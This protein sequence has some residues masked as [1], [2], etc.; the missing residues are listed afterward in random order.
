MKLKLVVVSMSVLG[1]VCSPAFAATTVKHKHAHKHH[2]RHYHAPSVAPAPVVMQQDYKDYKDTIPTPV[3]VIP[4]SAMLMDSMTQ[5]FG[6]SMPTPCNP[7]WFDRI[8][9]SGG[10][11]LDFGKFGTRTANYEGENYQRISLNDVYVNLAANVSDWAKAFASISYS[12]PTT[13]DNI[14]GI[15]TFGFPQYNAQYSSPYNGLST[16]NA[17]GTN[18]NLEQAYATIGN[19][20]VSPIFVQF[21]KQF[22]D[23]SRYQ[24]HPITRSMT[25]VMSEAL[26]TS[27]KLGFIAGGFTGSIYAF[28][29]PIPEIGHSS[30]P[31]NYGAALGFD[32]PGDQFGWDIGVGYMYNLMGA[33]DVADAVNFFESGNGYEDRASGVAAY[34]DINAGP[35]T[36]GARYTTATQRFNRFDLSENGIADRSAGLLQVNA[37]G[38][39][40]WAAGLQA[41]F[42]FDNIFDR[43]QTLYVGYQTSREA[44]GIS[45]PENRWLA[46]YNIDIVRNTNLG[47]EWDHDRAYSVAHGGTGNN[48]NLVS[49]RAAVQFG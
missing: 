43:N 1:L 26:E 23:F 28:D 13:S 47:I 18:F 37:E 10:L 33:Q 19:F 17:G 29:D 34:A 21:G 35:F 27:L 15:N 42:G 5:S 39:K 31:T 3:C 11:N 30:E 20:D 46:G 16:T 48:T 14:G 38:A 41:G 49:L 4:H 24:I 6:R 12:D 45:L 22:Q 7:A 8:Q 40:P 44:A 36:L 2:H 25:Q 9:L 32:M